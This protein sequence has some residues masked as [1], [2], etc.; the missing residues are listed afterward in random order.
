VTSQASGANQAFL[1]GFATG[2]TVTS[3]GASS[4]FFVP[5]NI[6]NAKRT[7][8]GPQYQEWNLELQ[9]GFGQKTSLSVNYVGNHQIRGAFQNTGLNAFCD[10]TCLADLG[11][12]TPRFSDLPGAPADPRFGTVTEVSNSNTAQYNGVTVSLLRRYSNLQFQA[13]YTYSH[14][15][16]LISNGGFLPFNFL[17]N[18]SPIN[19]QDPFNIRLFNRGNADYDVRHYVSG[20]YVWTTPTMKG[21][22]GAVGSWTVAGTV[23]WRTGYPFTVTDSGSTGVLNLFND[24]TSF[25]NNVFA[26]DLARGPV[27]CT[28]NALYTPCLNPTTQF[29][30]A[31]NGWGVQRRNQNWGPQYFDTDLTVMKNFHLPI[32]EASNLGIGVQFFN[33]LNHPN[34]DQPDADVR[35]STFGS[36]IN[37]V[38]VPTSIL[39]S[40]LGGDASPR[41]IQIR[42]TLTF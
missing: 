29:T 14:A 31:I 42:G 10:V 2:G 17:T 11:A 9:Q 22:L 7:I 16:D 5:P 1:T 26:N 40:F 19:Q 35:S 28:R 34:F 8:K 3:I 13:N 12:T 37:T 23:F 33:I 15:M 21:W 38:S 41:L 27:L 6:F 25:G 18:T 30:P 24:G 20:N 4:P 39:G 36:I 32:S